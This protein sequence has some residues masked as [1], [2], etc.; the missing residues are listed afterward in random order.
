[1]YQKIDLT[2]APQLH[3][4]HR[5]LTTPTCDLEGRLLAARRDIHLSHRLRDA[6]LDRRGHEGLQLLRDA[7]VAPVGCRRP[8]A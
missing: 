4:S 8:L 5:T 2:D 6:N 7:S 1:M 3:P